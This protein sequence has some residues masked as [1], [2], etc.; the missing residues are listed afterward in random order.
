MT[1]EPCVYDE[2]AARNARASATETARRS[3]MWSRDEIR[4]LRDEAIAAS[5]ALQAAEDRLN[6]AERAYADARLGA[7]P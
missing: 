5:E 3:R 6:A 7:K 4:A 2:I 1:N